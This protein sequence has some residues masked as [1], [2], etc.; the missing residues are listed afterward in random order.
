MNLSNCG[1]AGPGPAAPQRPAAAHGLSTSRTAVPGLSGRPGRAQ[2]TVNFE[3]PRP[4]GWAPAK[5]L[6]VTRVSGRGRAAAGRPGRRKW[7]AKS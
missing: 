2:I 6:R 3:S 7:Q 5:K 4:P 1:P